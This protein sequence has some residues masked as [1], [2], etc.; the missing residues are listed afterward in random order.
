MKKTYN[1][2]LTEDIFRKYEEKIRKVHAFWSYNF[3]SK[4]MIAYNLEA[5]DIKKIYK[6]IKRG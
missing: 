4:I 3:Y 1:F 5:K 2:T 6:I